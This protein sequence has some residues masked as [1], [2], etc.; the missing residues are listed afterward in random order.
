MVVKDA[1]KQGY[2]FVEAIASALPICDEFLVSDGYSSDGTFETLQKISL[3]NKKVKIYRNEW[4]RRSLYLI[5]DVSNG[6]RKKCKSDYLFYI[7]APEIVHEDDV[8]LL[9]SYPEMFPEV[10]TFCLPYTSIISNFKVQEEFRLRLCRNIERINLTG[11]AWAFS[12]SKKFIRSEAL[13]KMKHP[14]KLLS[15]VGRGIEWTYACSLNN[16]RCRAAHLPK[17]LF[18]YYALFKENFI[19]RC[20]GHAFHLNLPFY[21]DVLKEVENEQGE[22]FFEKTAEIHRGWSGINYS[23]ALGILKTEDHPKIMQELIAK[24]ATINRYFVRDSVLE[25]IRTA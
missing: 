18:R 1:I 3:L 7:Q 5:A 15:Y 19:E 14:K 2:P 25:T 20:K 12:V 6:L 24:R 23:A 17:P 4:S 10:D 16:I 9:K 22:A 13:N 21:Y 8:Q 11:D